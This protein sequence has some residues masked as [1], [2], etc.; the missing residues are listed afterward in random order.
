MT[1]THY[2]TLTELKQNAAKALE[3]WVQDDEGRVE[4]FDYARDKARKAYPHHLETL[5][6]AEVPSMTEALLEVIISAPG[7]AQVEDEWG[8][9]NIA[10]LAHEIIEW[11]IWDHLTNRW[12]ALLEEAIED[13]AEWAANRRNRLVDARDRLIEA[14][15]RFKRRAY[16]LWASDE[17][18]AAVQETYSIK[19]DLAVT[20]VSDTIV[21]T[22]TWRD[23]PRRV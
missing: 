3:R 23:D 7:L 19:C 5:A 17:E 16:D 8:C 12:D 11:E 15:H 22:R 6:S 4:L 1:T 10:T 18:A 13:L 2:P 9:S 14:C 20:R 21:R